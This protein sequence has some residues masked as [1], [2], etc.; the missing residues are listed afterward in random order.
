MIELLISPKRAK[1][2]PW[3][4]MLLSAFFV[5]LAVVVNLTIPSLAGGVITFAMIPAIPL[6]WMLLVREEKDDEKMA[7]LKTRSFRYHLPIIE[8][9]AFFFL[10]ATIAYMAWYAA[11]ATINPASADDMF[12][13]QLKEIKVIGLSSNDAAGNLIQPSFALHVLEHNLTV[14]AFMFIFTL[15][16]GIGSIYLLLWNAS[17]IGVFIGSK[18][19]QL[20]VPGM[21]HS[22]LAILPHGILEVTAYFLASIA[23]G[24]LS[25]ALMHEHHKRDEF[26]FILTDVALITI[27][28][29]AA[30]VLAAVLES[31]G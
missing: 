19:T 20:G 14:L 15:V 5:S 31:T 9:F 13:A 30:L 10:G 29:L 3:E 24:I 27:A 21:L 28:S 11:L 25:F 22:V 4:L 16:Y 1:R 18:L 17:I 7:M 6:I 2:E 26:K 8:V 23:G 12:A